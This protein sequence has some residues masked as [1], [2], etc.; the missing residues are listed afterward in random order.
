MTRTFIGLAVGSGLEGVDAAVVRTRG[1]GLNLTAAVERATR[2]P[3]PHTVRELLRP[4]AGTAPAR[5]ANAELTRRLAEVAT[6][7]VRGAASQADRSDR[8]VFAVGLLDP[9]RPGPA[10][11]APDWLEVADRVADQTGLTV[12]HGFRGRDR[13]AGGNGRPITPAADFLLFRDPAEE[14]L[15]VHLGAVASAVL[16][17]AGGNVAAVA[18]FDGGPGNGLLD[19]LVTHGTRGREASDPGGKRAVQGC[20]RD[21]LLLRWLEHPFLHRKPPRPAGDPFGPAFVAAAFD[22]A[23]QLDATLPDLLCTATHFLVRS[24]ADGVGRWLPAPTVPRRVFVSGGGVRNGLLWQL[25]AQAFEGTPPVRLEE[26]GAPPLARNAAGAAILAALLFDGVPA[27]LPLLTGAGAARAS[28]HL[29]PGDVRNWSRCATWVAEQAGDY[30]R[31]N[32]AA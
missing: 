9:Q 24:L 1:V 7:V 28:G 23:R 32:R 12:A 22:A 31:F 14:R 13:A 30:P 20:C 26:V 11:A 2:V 5:N 29:S 6:Q 25:L 17:P 8:D 27:N 3:F 4:P 10:S 16:L 21:A 19:A 15:L 18:G